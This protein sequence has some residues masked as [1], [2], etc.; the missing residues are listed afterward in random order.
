M[1]LN[2]VPIHPQATVIPRSGMLRSISDDKHLKKKTMK[3]NARIADLLVAGFAAAVFGAG[4]TS[5]ASE[6]RV[7][8]IEPDGGLVEIVLNAGV[9]LSVA[10]DAPV[11][12]S[13]PTETRAIIN[14]EHSELDLSI[15]RRDQTGT[16][17]TYPAYSTVAAGNVLKA[18]LAAVAE[19]A[20]DKVSAI[21]F[22]TKQHYLANG[23]TTELIAWYPAVST[24]P[25][26]DVTY[27]SGVVSFKVD[28]EAD[29]MLSNAAEGSKKAGNMFSDYATVSAK[30]L[31][32]SHLLTQIKVMA[33]AVDADA[34]KAWGKI[35]SIKLKDEGA[36]ICAVT[37]PGTKDGEIVFT[38]EADASDSDKNLSL[39]AKTADKDDAITYPLELPL[40]TVDTDSGSITKKNETACGYAM[41]E[42]LLPASD[43]STKKLTLLVS[44]EKATDWPVEL[45]LP[46]NTGKTDGFLKGV[47]YGILLKFTAKEISPSGQITDWEDYEWPTG[48][49]EFNGE[50]EL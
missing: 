23:D 21:T 25:A 24:A 3:L 20:T 42:P 9:S 32:F 43:G 15:L 2:V 16:P 30:L 39:V 40:A 38:P 29:I 7:S 27:A 10:P 26:D 4:C 50:I 34:Q 36:K 12:A 19:G 28:G 11:H 22:G 31:T 49:G 41:F 13:L 8:P 46:K 5:S 18:K 45:V 17:L 35:T 44:T 37:L 14:S 47:A 48:E 1:G 6:E 33:Y